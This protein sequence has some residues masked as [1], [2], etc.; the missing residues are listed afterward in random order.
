LNGV[1]VID[2]PTDWTSHDVVAKFRGIARTRSVGHL[3]TLDPI[4]TG[5]LPL[6]VGNATRLAR[7]FVNSTK[8]YDA[9]I[10]FGFST[11]TYDRAGTAVGNPAEHPTLESIQTVL[12]RFLGPIQQMP[13]QYSAKKV[14]GVAAYVSARKKITVELQPIDIE[15]YELRIDSYQPPDLQLHVRCSGG[16]YVRTLA[17]DLGQVLGCGA[18]LQELRRVVSGDF[19]IE[20]AH[21]LPDLQRLSDEGRLT[22]ALLPAAELLPDFPPVYVDAETEGFIRQ[23]RDFHASPFRK[24]PGTQFVKA[25]TGQNT[26]LAI[27]ELKMPHVY[28]PVL[29]LV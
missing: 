5:V 26:L 21:T 7:F 22:E 4:A 6:I 20:Q 12:L 9:T 25:M 2:K 8:T 10:C 19:R 1:V 18:H 14:A 29:V 3:G 28:H 23:G 27:G 16:T 13:P 15:M 24:N 17:H 11:D